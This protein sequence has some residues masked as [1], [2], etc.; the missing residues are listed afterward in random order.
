MI[1]TEAAKSIL[2]LFVLER[3]YLTQ[4]ITWLEDHVDY[5]SLQALLYRRDDLTLAQQVNIILKHS[6]RLAVAD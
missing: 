5:L 4:H 1:L 2:V 3:L 6:K